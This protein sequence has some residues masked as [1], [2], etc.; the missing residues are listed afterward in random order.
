MVQQIIYKSFSMMCISSL[1][2]NILEE[3]DWRVSKSCLGTM[4]IMLGD[5]VNG[6]RD[7]FHMVQ[8]TVYIVIWNDAHNQFLVKI[9]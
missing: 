7:S 8:Q 9:T 4:L 6:S 2:V 5:G 1:S 3:Y